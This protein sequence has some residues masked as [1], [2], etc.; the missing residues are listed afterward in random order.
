MP[1][2]KFRYVRRHGNRDIEPVP[3]VWARAVLALRLGAVLAVIIAITVF[4]AR[5]A[6][7]VVV[8]EQATSLIV[9]VAFLLPSA[10][11]LGRG[12]WE[13]R[14]PPDPNA[15]LPAG[16]DGGRR[17]LQMPRESRRLRG[18]GREAHDETDPGGG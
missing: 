17:V 12:Y 5:S 6:M 14:H 18:S 4:F 1:A 13:K 8:G 10:L 7:G 16:R 2:P 3:G 9:L 15:G 11:V